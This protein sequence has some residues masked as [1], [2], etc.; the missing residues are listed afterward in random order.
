[1]PA[2]TV[3]PA[4]LARCLVCCPLCFPTTMGSQCWCIYYVSWLALAF[5][6]HTTERTPVSWRTVYNPGEGGGGVSEYQSIVNDLCMCLQTAVIWEQPYA[7]HLLRL[8]VSCAAV[9]GL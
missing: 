8:D 5:Q 3:M 1:V 4:C 9:H 2:D 7:Q 6:W